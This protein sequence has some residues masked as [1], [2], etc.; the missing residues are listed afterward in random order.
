MRYWKE[1][2]QYVLKIC[3][4]ERCPRPM[5]SY[6]GARR[7]ADRTPWYTLKNGRG[8]AA[9]HKSERIKLGLTRREHDK[10]RWM[11]AQANL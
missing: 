4:D 11:K 6:R 5:W 1:I 8:S 7:N 2:E 3:R 10:Y 9:I